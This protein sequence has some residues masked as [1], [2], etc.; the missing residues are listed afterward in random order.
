MNAPNTETPVVSAVV[1]TWNVA[2]YIDGCLRSLYRS[3]GS[4]PI[5]TILVDN[6]SHDTTVEII[7]R[8]FPEATLIRN[9][10]NRGLTAANN[11]GAA[12]ANGR[13]VLFLNPDTVMVGDALAK[14]VDT[15]EQNPDIAALGPRLVDG[16]GKI[17]SDMGAHTPNAWTLTNSFLL[18]S[19]I[20]PRF[21]PG[22]TRVGDIHGLE[23]CDW[24]CGACVLVRREVA[25]EFS[26]K[27]FG[28]GDVFEYCIQ[29]RDAGW[30]V[31]LTGDAEVV[32][33]NGRSWIKSQPHTL[34][35]QPSPL[36]TYVLDHRG[37]TEAMIAIFAMRIGI[38]VRMLAHRLLYFFSRE[39]ERLHKAN[40]AAR[41]L[42]SDEYSVFRKD[43]R[44]TPSS[45][46]R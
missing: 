31:S 24:I 17:S 7:E 39:P 4:M 13:Y 35:G 1:V 2:E 22:W 14:M 30:R 36:I 16:D 26:W 43:P 45:Y 27:A 42:A 12:E 23:D 37:P 21:F 25:A 33:F 11:Q 8:E 5:E 10:E 15:M 20:S 40:K 6:H 29:M 18:L 9:A 38:R 3:A 34:S 32:H 44:A 41:F 19:R 46:P 28:L